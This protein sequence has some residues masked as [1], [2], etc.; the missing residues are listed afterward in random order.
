MGYYVDVVDFTFGEGIDVGEFVPSH[1]VFDQNQNITLTGTFRETMMV[2]DE[3]LESI[4]L[5][6]M[7]VLKVKPSEL[8]D[9]SSGIFNRQ[10]KENDM[11]IYPNP[12]KHYLNIV[13]MEGTGLYEYRFED[14]SGRI[15]LSGTTS[16]TG[17]SV[18]I[19]NLKSGTYIIRLIGEDWIGRKTF[20][21]L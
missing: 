4:G 15:I 9:F 17:K 13:A 19:S 10:L 11:A 2:G 14:I 5:K 21:K 8:F 3:I 1:M 6:Q 7:F 20:I 12:A 18:D 16:E